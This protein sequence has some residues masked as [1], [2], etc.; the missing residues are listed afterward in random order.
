M[1]TGQEKAR[2]YIEGPDHVNFQNV[3]FDPY[4]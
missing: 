1:G 4:L 3:N 2:S